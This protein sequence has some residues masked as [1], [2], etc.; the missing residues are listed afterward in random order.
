MSLIIPPGYAQLVL[1]YLTTGDAE[2]QVNTLGLDISAASGDGQD[3]V[4]KAFTAWGATVM[5]N[6]CNST[7]LTHATLYVGQDGGPPTVFD[8][9]GAAVVGSVTN[10]ALP[11]NCAWLV[12]KRTDLAGRRG[13]GRVY[14][15]GIAETAVDAAGI[16][17]GSWVSDM[18]TAFANFVD[19]LEDAGVPPGVL[20]PVIL[21]RSEGAGVEPVPTP[22]TTFVTEAKIATQRRR[23]RP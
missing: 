11:P 8:S 5:V 13:R 18:N 22:V 3:I 9:V 21:H 19:D 1:S 14:V 6:V 10:A 20:T 4:D 17:T 12:R 2:P 23:L 16:I 15:P 7:R